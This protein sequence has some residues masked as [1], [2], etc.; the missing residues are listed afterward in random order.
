M[1]IMGSARAVG[2]RTVVAAALVG[3]AA[4]VL[5]A[6]GA[7]LN[8]G[9]PDNSTTLSSHNYTPPPST[10][11]A[12]GQESAGGTPSP[13]SSKAAFCL[14]LTSHQAALADF[15]TTATAAV[16]VRPLWAAI[17]ARAPAELRLTIGELEVAVVLVAQGRA[18]AVDAT[19]VATDLQAAQTWIRRNCP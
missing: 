3:V 5:T 2:D 12:A 16:S 14:E 15:P 18:G 1:S 4:T 9:T 6:C 17:A 19:Q 8:S 11:V 7:A 13:T 10:S